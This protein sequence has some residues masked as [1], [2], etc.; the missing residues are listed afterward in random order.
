[1][2][3]FFHP[4]SHSQ[5]IRIQYDILWVKPGLVYKKV[6]C[7][8]TNI[9][10]ALIGCSLPL[11]IKSHHQ[12]HRPVPFDEHCPGKENFRPFFQTY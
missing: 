8:G 10:P 9:Y 2:P 4:G 12:R 11:L 1:M 6:I 3:V 7:P 5:H